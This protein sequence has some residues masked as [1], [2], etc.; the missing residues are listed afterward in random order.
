MDL[1]EIKDLMRSFDKSSLSRFKLKKDDFEIVFQ[2]GGKPV[3]T[4]LDTQP[5][6]YIQ[7]QTAKTPQQ[8]TTPQDNQ[9]KKSI[10]DKT[11]YIK[12][13]MVGTFY[14][15]PSPGAP[16]F[17]QEGDTIKKGAT[18]AIIEAMKIMNEIESEFDCK[19]LEVL[20]SDGEPVE[21]DQP[22]FAI[23]KL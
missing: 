13:P 19:I 14:Q 18:I 5:T 22:L 1:K 12:S 9:P 15:A 8:E 23:E 21:Y 2:K 17:V 11:Q 10:D 4:Q 20:V 7:T 6:Q 3:T 16:A